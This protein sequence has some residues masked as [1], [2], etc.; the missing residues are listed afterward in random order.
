MERESFMS[1]EIAELLNSSFI[2]VKVDRE[3]RPDLDVIY[4]NYIEATTGSGG[5]PLNVFLTPELQPVFGGTYFPGPPGPNNMMTASSDAVSFTE[6]LQKM[7]DVW[8]TQEGKCRSS[9]NEITKQL[10]SFAEEGH[11]H[12]ERDFD[13]NHNFVDLDI[14]LLEEAYQTLARQ[15]DKKNGGLSLAPKFP[16]PV[17]LRFL[18]QLGRWPAAVTDIVGQR[19]CTAAANMA[20][21]TL[22][23]MARGGIRD[24]IGY[25]FARYSVTM[26]W[27]DYTMTRCTQS[28]TNRWQVFAA[29]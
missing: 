5:W 16:V 29:L 7:R 21:T 27:S 12:G 20:I 11:S 24:H 23:K 15:Y 1:Q 22:Q 2:P 25:G 8:S 3:E 10:R 18:L 9:A 28:Y 13:E 4:M 26:D 14:E 19:E 17:K 6:I